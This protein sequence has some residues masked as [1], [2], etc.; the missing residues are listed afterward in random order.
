MRDRCL[1]D[2]NQTPGVAGATPGYGYGTPLGF[3][4]YHPKWGSALPE[5]FGIFRDFRGEFQIVPS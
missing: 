1:N 3:G 2:E 5:P 4:G